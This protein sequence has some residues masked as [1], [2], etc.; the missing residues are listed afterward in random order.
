MM[1]AVLIIFVLAI[2]TCCITQILPPLF[3]WQN[4]CMVV[5]RVDNEP[6]VVIDNFRNRHIAANILGEINLMY[7][8]LIKHLKKNRMNTIWRDNIIYLTNNYNP[9][10]LGEHIPTNLNYTSYVR[11]KGKKIRLCLRTRENR[12][13]F[14]DMNTI[15][16]VAIHELSH[17]MTESYG[18]EDDFW[19]AFKFLLFEAQSLGL[20]KLI[21][22]KKDPQK[23]CGIVINS[24]PA[25]D[26]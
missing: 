26:E 13:I 10:V 17:M 23:Y 1:I 4:D 16:F 22:Y 19:K 14:H 12:N 24:N 20:I 7:V 3:T 21:D 9:D 2:I 11:N 8:T 18:H 15:R 6:Y 25:H 5:S